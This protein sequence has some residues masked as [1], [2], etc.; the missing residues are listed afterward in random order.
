[1][2][3]PEEIMLSVGRLRHAT[4]LKGGSQHERDMAQL[5]TKALFSS[6]LAPVKTKVEAAHAHLLLQAAAIGGKSISFPVNPRT[7]MPET[8]LDWIGADISFIPPTHNIKP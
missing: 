8:L 4:S 7:P 1:L 3:E 2:L 5:L 6:Y